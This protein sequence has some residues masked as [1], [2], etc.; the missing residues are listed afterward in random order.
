MLDPHITTATSKLR[1]D[2]A[3]LSVRW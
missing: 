2:S 3:R 1:P